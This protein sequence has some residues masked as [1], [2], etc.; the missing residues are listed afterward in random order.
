MKPRVMKYTKLELENAIK[1]VLGGMR[2]SEAHKAFNIPWTTLHD[3]V[4]KMK[5]GAMRCSCGARRI[6]DYH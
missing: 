6:H 2:M 4:K 3:N 1:A 5:K